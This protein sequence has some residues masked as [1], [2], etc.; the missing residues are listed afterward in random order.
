M[1][2]RSGQISYDQIRAEFGNPN[3]F[4]L[5]E[6]LDLRYGDLNR[7]SY[8]QPINNGRDYKPSDFYGYTSSKVVNDSLVLHWDAWPTMGSHSGSGTA[9][10][11]LSS[12]RTRGEMYNGSYWDSKNGGNFVFDG[13]DDYI[14]SEARDTFNNYADKITVDFWVK[15][16]SPMNYGQGVGQGVLNN[17]DRVRDGNIWL[18]HGN[19][20]SNTVTFYVW[21]SR[22]LV[23]GGSSSTLS[24]GTW[25]NLVCTMDSQGSQ[26]YTN[27]QQSG[28]GGNTGGAIINNRDASIFAGGDLR[29]EWRRMAGAISAL[30]VYNK[31]LTSSEVTQN[32]NALVGRL[33]Q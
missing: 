26:F 11:D 27:G 21:T 15:W 13:M 23:S 5:K 16:D 28:T 9:I 25:Y 18:M 22:G 33:D 14:V 12:V 29:Y 10:T 30:K 2:P 4:S 8:I 3:N 19:L 32:Y 20:G 1:L 7:F 24:T 6:A 17:Q 31:K